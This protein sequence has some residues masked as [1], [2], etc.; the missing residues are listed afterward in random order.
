MQDV[1]RAEVEKLSPGLPAERAGMRVG[2][3]IVRF[4]ER[5][6]KDFPALKRLVGQCE[7]GDEVPV[8][9]LRDNQRVR[10]TIIVGTAAG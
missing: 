3:I 6:V 10:L 1:D 9:V 5:P 8:V 4:N 2:D 7:P